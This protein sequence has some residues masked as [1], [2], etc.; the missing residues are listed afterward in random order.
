MKKTNTVALV[1]S[2]IAAAVSAAA[3]AVAIV[4]L[5]KS[6]GRNK[7]TVSEYDF[8]DGSADR[9]DYGDISEEDDIGSDTL[10]F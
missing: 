6:L 9:S 5:V 4:A 3:L 8:Y 1:L 7:I 10:A 2:I